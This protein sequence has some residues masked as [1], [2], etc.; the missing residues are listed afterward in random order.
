MSC[1]ITVDPVDMD[2]TQH[3]IQIIEDQCRV[4]SEVVLSGKDEAKGPDHH[5]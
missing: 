3:R 4:L 5:F 2:T 1:H